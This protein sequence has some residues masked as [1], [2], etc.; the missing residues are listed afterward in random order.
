MNKRVALLA[1]VLAAAAGCG[2]R[3]PE[4]MSAGEVAGELAQLRI[5]PGLWELTSAVVEA[6]APGLPREVRNRMV[7]PRA[8]SATTAESSSHWPVA[9]R[10]ALV[11]ASF[12]SDSPSPQ[13]ATVAQSNGI[14]TMKRI[15][16][17]P[18]GSCRG[19]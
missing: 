11:A 10:A 3:P 5:E 13:A 17:S 8:R 12:G 16:A 15:E 18:S 7:G 2:E 14:R 6:S 4:N 1:A 9:G 19:A